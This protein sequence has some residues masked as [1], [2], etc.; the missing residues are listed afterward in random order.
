[1][2]DEQ[3][4]LKTDQAIAPVSL[5]VVFDSQN[6]CLIMCHVCVCLGFAWSTGLNQWK[7]N[8]INCKDKEQ[9]VTIHTK[10]EN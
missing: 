3:S 4:K 9:M 8:Y 1:M 10:L 6:D 2:R 7:Y 5:Q